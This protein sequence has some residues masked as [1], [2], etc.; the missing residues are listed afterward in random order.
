MNGSPRLALLEPAS[1]ELLAV[2]A[3]PSKMPL[4]K[5]LR[6]ASRKALF[7]EE[8]TSALLEQNRPLADELPGVAPSLD[9]IITLKFRLQVNITALDSANNRFYVRI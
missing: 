7:W 9:R 4:Q 6:R 3:E 8:E 5:A 2:A 1:G